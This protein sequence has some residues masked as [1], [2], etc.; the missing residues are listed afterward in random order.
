MI[1][2]ITAKPSSATD[3]RALSL[4]FETNSAIPLLRPKILVVASSDVSF[5]RKIHLSDMSSMTSSIHEQR[6]RLERLRKSDQSRILT[7]PFRLFNHVLSSAFQ[8]TKQTFS[9]ER[10]IHVK[11][12]GI[13]GVLKLD[14]TGWYV[15]FV[16]G[17]SKLIRLSYSRFML[18]KQKQV[19]DSHDCLSTWWNLFNREMLTPKSP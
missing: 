18:H 3:V 12:R 6:R 15:H 5:S 7:R 8:H 19:L 10:F 9:M 4:H 1:L 2:T 17:F 16:V 14:E 11:L 13:S